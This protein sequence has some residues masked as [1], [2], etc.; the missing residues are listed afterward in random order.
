MYN[1]HLFHIGY[2]FS[3]VDLSVSSWSQNWQIKGCPTLQIMQFFYKV[4]KGG[5][6]THVQK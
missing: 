3:S 6:Q 4:Q 5:G 1:I 2:L